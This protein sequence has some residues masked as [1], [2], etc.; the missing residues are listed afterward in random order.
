MRHFDL[1][2]FQH[3]MLYLFPALIF[4]FIF[5]IGLAFS[6]WRNSDSKARKKNITYTFPGGIEDRDAPFPLVM[7]LTIIGTVVWVFGYILAHGLLGVKI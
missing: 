2:N 4:I 5:G 7:T 1:L 3:V 6:H